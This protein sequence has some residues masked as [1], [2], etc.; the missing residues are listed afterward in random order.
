MLIID[1]F[2]ENPFVNSAIIDL[3]NGQIETFTLYGTIHCD[4]NG[5]LSVFVN[6][7]VGL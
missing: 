7:V 3:S 1:V 5:P 2:M 6:K 4:Y